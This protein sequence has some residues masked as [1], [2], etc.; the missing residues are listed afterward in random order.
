[1]APSLL[2]LAL[3]GAAF[4]QTPTV[5]LL[6][7][8]GVSYSLEASV[9]DA[10]PS[11]TTYVVNCPDE[12]QDDCTIG[13]EYNT[14]TQGPSSWVSELSTS[15]EDYG[16]VSQSVGCT[17]NWEDNEA[18]CSGV[19]IVD[20]ITS[21]QRADTFSD[22]SS[23]AAPVAI[24]GGLE[25]LSQVPVTATTTSEVSSATE[26]AYSSSIVEISTTIIVVSSSE[27]SVADDTTTTGSPSTTFT[28]TSTP[29]SSEEEETSETDESGADR[30]LASQNVVIV[31]VVALIGGL[32]MM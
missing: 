6:G 19:M 13:G 14:V 3:A 2:L 22:L 30:H 28:S 16:D 1:M 15:Y 32:L 31:G 29:T 4:A 26:E 5:R 11:L 9:V 12:S 20:G 10:S 27:T 17:L 8:L 18:I 24:T 25:H 7:P 23:I 21:T